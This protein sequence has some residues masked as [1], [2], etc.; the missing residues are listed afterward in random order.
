MCVYSRVGPIILDPTESAIPWVYYYLPVMLNLYIIDLLNFLL[1]IK[2]SVK[3]VLSV[4]ENTLLD[5]SSDQLML[6]TYV[7]QSFW[8]YSNALSL[9]IKDIDISCKHLRFKNV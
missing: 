6:G 9:Q 8:T 7:S 5:I 2:N 3:V 4:K 1:W